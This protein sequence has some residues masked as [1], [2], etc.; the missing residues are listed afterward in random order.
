[1][2]RRLATLMLN[3]YPLAF[4]R[5]YGDEM[6]ALL[7]DTPAGPLTSLNLLRGAL[8]AHVRPPDGLASLVDADDRLRASTSGVLA[9]WVAFAAAGFG[10]YKTTEDRG[11]TAAGNAHGVLGAAH[12]AVQVL[13]IVASCAVV[14][15]ALPLIASALAH[16]RRERGLR[17]VVIR[18]FLVLVAF[19][20]LTGLL[21]WFAHSRPVGHAPAVGHAAFIAWIL[22]GL[23]CGAVCVI[24]ARQALFAVPVA[25]PRLRSTLAF[26]T[27]VT[28]AMVAI[29]LAIALYAITLWLDVP[30]LAAT[31]NGPLGATSTT[32]ALIAQLAVMAVAGGLASTATRRGW[33]TLQPPAGA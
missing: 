30:Q 1:M 28:V 3:L 19:A 31:S 4:R 12:L 17:R 16:A 9:C 8:L 23:V 21:V 33:R 18:P 14:L 2:A 24:A 6:R 29:V 5:R 7:D 13:A 11:F 22:A 20:G 32:V 27:L 15:G 10:F 26:G 25:R